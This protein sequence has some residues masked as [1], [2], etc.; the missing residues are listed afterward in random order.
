[1]KNMIL[2]LACA[3]PCSHFAQTAYQ[4]ELISEINA[5]TEEINYQPEKL[6]AERS[7]V[8]F[9]LNSTEPGQQW[10]PYTL[11]DALNDVNCAIELNPDDASLY[12]MRAE[13]KR[14]INRDYRGAIRDMNLAIALEPL[15]PQWFLQRANY[16]KLEQGCLDYQQCADLH[17]K[18][19]IAI[20]RE[21]CSELISMREK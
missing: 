17:D 14:D 10:V 21:T 8:V 12:S 20:V 2:L 3:M 18:R 1:M 6:Y 9:L 11:A 4:Q 15:N 19:C 5:L 13:Y 7:K 16:Q